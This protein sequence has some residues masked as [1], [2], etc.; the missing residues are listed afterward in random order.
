MET[1][2]KKEKKSSQENDVD[3]ANW[4]NDIES[5]DYYYDD[6]TGY[7]VYDPDKD[8]ED[9]DEDEDENS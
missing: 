1:P 4:A 9:E 7:E 2:E 6:S 8:D 5:R 3:K